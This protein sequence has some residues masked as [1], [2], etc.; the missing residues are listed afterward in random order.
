SGVRV[1]GIRASLVGFW[2]L[3]KLYRMTRVEAAE[4]FGKELS[5]EMFARLAFVALAAAL[6]LGLAGA[7]KAPPAG[8]EM[9]GVLDAVD[10]KAGTFTIRRI[11]VDVDDVLLEKMKQRDRDVD[12]KEARDGKDAVKVS[13]AP[14]AEIYIKFRT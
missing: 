13:L 10:V 4:D 8:E 7:A 5:M 1:H 12:H 14:K 3:W 2:R 6:F 11:G 9:T